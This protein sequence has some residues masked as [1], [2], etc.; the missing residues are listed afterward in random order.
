MIVIT[1]YKYL[2]NIKKF[3]EIM[4]I[5]NVVFI[6]SIKQKKFLCKQC[7]HKYLLSW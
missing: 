5:T 2:P 1:Y 3:I 7:K 4:K 6:P